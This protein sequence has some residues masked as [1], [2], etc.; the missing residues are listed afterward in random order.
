MRCLRTPFLLAAVGLAA[1]LAPVSVH[2]AARLEGIPEQVREGDRVEVRWSALDPDVEEVELELSV[3][4]SR[5]VR[6]SPEMEA[7]EGRYVWRVTGGLAGPARI[8]LRAG[9]ERGEREVASHAFT[10]VPQS[11]AH[12]AAILAWPDGW[13]LDERSGPAA[14]GSLAAAHSRYALLVETP[15]AATTS[16]AGAEFEDQRTPTRESAHALVL[17]AAGTLR[18]FRAPRRTPLRN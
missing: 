3:A 9:G 8:R 11:F 7:L 16:S 12:P 17:P 18:A 2:A 10:I 6:I 5:W 15:V 13:D 4:G 14:A 1:L